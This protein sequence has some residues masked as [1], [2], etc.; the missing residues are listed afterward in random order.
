[1]LLDNEQFKFLIEKIRDK[2][3]KSIFISS[4]D[5]IYTLSKD[6]YIKLNFCFEDECYYNS[7]I[8]NIFI[9]YNNGKNDNEVYISSYKNI[10]IYIYKWNVNSYWVTLIKR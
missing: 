7:L 3:I 2:E 10:D 8:E 4:W 6:G 5:S 9:E 1:M